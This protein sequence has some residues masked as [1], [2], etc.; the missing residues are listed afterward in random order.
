MEDP[1]GGFG[2]VL[3]IS[4]IWLGITDYNQ[5]KTI[6]EMSGIISQCSGAIDDANNNIQNLNSQIDDV[7]SL[8]WSDYDAMGYALENLSNGQEVHNPCTVPSN[9]TPN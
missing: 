8:A 6:S 3:I 5:N 4:L 9:V 7:Q 1:L 2:I